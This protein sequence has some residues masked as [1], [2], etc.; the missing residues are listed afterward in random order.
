MEEI[1]RMEA[2]VVLVLQVTIPMEDQGNRQA[3][4]AVELE[5]K[6]MEIQD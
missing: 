3:A 4:E 6:E 5:P 1:L 2:E